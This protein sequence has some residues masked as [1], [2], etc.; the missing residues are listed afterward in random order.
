MKFRP[1]L[2]AILKHFGYEIKK[3][4]TPIDVETK[5]EIV[6][7]AV[8]VLAND[9]RLTELDWE[10]IRIANRASISKI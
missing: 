6:N 5:K 10:I 7:L 1:F 4:K 9:E 3:A 8:K 2:N